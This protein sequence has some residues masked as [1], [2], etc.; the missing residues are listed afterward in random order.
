MLHLPP[1]QA[2]EPSAARQWKATAVLSMLERR[3]GEEELRKILE[4]YVHGAKA[5]GKAL[6][7]GAAAPGGGTDL[8][9]F[10]TN[11]WIG[12]CLC[13]QVLGACKHQHKVSHR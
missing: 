3:I 7:A 10:L 1:A 5:T 13:A 11:G 4:K 12:C 6:E 8:V 2:L 9:R